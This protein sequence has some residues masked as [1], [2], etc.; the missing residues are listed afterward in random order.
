MSKKW[1]IKDYNAKEI[2]DKIKEG[3]IKVPQYQRGQ[4]WKP[5]QKKD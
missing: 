3:I 2:A 1:K 5:K 4:V